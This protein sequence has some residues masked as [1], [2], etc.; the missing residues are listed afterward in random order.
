LLHGAYQNIKEDSKFIFKIPVSGTGIKYNASVDDNAVIEQDGDYL[1]ISPNKDYNGTILVNLSLDLSFILNVQS[2]NDKPLISK[3]E[4][5][6]I[7]EDEEFKLNLF[8]SDAEEDPLTYGATVDGNAKVNVFNNE[9]TITP[10]KN[11]NGPIKVTLAVS[12]GEDTDETNFILNVKPV[13]D[14]PVLLSINPIPI[15]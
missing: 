2:V 3:I 9:L 6:T 8:A 12:D 13:N 4:N 15:L 7:N 1:I 5:Q 14:A 11:Y 10:Y